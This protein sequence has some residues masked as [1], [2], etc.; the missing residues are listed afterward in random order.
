MLTQ[1]NKEGAGTKEGAQGGG[2][3]HAENFENLVINLCAG[4]HY[5]HSASLGV[6]LDAGTEPFVNKLCSPAALRR[7][8]SP[9]TAAGFMLLE[10]LGG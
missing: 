3:H 8:C 1:E 10:I 7:Q 9:D 4:R 5:R 2:S 6:M